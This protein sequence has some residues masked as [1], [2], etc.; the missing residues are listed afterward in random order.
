LTLLLDTQVALWWLTG[1]RRL[2]PASR[3]LMAA[4]PCVVSA[5]SVW[6]VAIKHRIGKLPIP[7]RRFRD[8]MRS[9][10]APIVSI[11]DTKIV[12]LVPMQTHTKL[13]QC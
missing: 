5:A 1:S 8:E 9:A 12:V 3:Q 13:Q 11:S 2:S 6:E 7:P 4:E 10:G